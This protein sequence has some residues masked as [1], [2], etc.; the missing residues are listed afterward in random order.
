MPVGRLR[1]SAKYGN[2]NPT[3]AAPMKTRR[4]PRNLSP[5]PA[6]STR[7]TSPSIIRITINGTSHPTHPKSPPYRSANNGTPPTTANNGIAT[8]C[9][10]PVI[11]ATS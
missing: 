5:P 10:A 11:S 3:Y 9:R 8:Q 7:T 2:S 6:T 4:G 1:T